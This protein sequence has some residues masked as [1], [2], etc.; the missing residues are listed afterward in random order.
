MR[1]DGYCVG[2]DGDVIHI[3]EGSRKLDRKGRRER[4]EKVAKA[5]MLL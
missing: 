3:E 4:K 5:P 1:Y 2:L